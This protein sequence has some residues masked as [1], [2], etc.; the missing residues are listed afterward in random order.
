[1]RSPCS[2]CATRAALEAA[3]HVGIAWALSGLLRAVPVHAAR[4]QVFLPRE[5]TRAAGLDVGRMLDGH[6]DDALRT[7]AQQIADAAW[8]HIDAARA[9]RSRVPRAAVPA[10]LPAVLALAL[11]QAA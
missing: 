4:R 8:A 9:L 5:L 6:P 1:M 10:L 7:V 11:S 2:A 3:R